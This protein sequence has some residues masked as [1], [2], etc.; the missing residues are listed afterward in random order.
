MHTAVET[1]KNDRRRS[2]SGLTVLEIALGLVLLT[3]LVI[4]FV[5]IQRKKSD[6]KVTNACRTNQWHWNTAIEKIEW[7]LSRWKALAPQCLGGQ[8]KPVYTDQE[9]GKLIMHTVNFYRPLVKPMEYPGRVNV[10]RE[11]NFSMGQPLVICSDHDYIM[12]S[13]EKARISKDTTAGLLRIDYAEGHVGKR[14][15][16]ESVAVTYKTWEFSTLPSKATGG[17]TLVVE[18]DSGP[19]KEIS[20]GFKKTTS[21]PNTIF[22]ARRS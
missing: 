1:E 14:L 5:L 3:I 10:P 18:E 4:S 21:R 2:Q 8:F 7:E 12:A 13:V 17:L 16:R 11:H 15:P 6:Q 19:A 22:L 9:T 20:R